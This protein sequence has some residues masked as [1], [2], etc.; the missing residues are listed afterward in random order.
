MSGIVSGM[1]N[2]GSEMGG[3]LDSFLDFPDKY[4]GWKR[5][6]LYIIYDVGVIL[7][8]VLMFSMAN[9][10]LTGGGFNSLLHPSITSLMG[11]PMAVTAVGF[12][13]SWLLKDILGE[14]KGR[15]LGK[16]L[17]A[18][19]PVFLAVASTAFI[20]NGGMYAGHFSFAHAATT[21]FFIIGALIAPL[22]IFAAG[23]AIEVLGRDDIQI[24]T[25]RPPPP[26]PRENWRRDEARAQL[27]DTEPGR[28]LQSS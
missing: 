26:P 24:I 5:K 3:M 2:M 15:T 7:L 17:L 23:H 1:K 28:L 9:G 16:I 22:S 14:K 11:A 21:P 27:G 25:N 4:E 12:G 18:L 13:V 19:T 8:G 10:L 20:L 6:A